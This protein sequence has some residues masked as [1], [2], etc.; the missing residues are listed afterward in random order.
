MPSKISVI[1]ILYFSEYRPV[2]SL[3]RFNPR[4]FI[5]FV[6]VVNRSVSLIS[7][8]DLL[9]LMYRDP[10]NFRV[11]VLNSATLPTLMSSSSFLVSSLGFSMYSMSP[12]NHDNFTSFPVWISFISFSSLL[13]LGLPKL[14]GESKHPYLVPDLRGNVLSFS[15]LRMMFAVGLLHMVF[16]MLR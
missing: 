12:A 7:S 1:S 14:C 3:G 13:C 9:L 15:P 6:A 8:S 5:L 16:I 11:L 10:R 4:Y 2:G